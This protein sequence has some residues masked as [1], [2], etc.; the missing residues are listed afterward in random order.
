MYDMVRLCLMSVCVMEQNGA[1]WSE[2]GGVPNVIIM[3]SD[4]GVPDNCVPRKKISGR[5]LEN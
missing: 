2:I 1:K 5:I 3:W 4:F